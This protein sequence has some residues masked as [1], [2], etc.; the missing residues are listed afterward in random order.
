MS[1]DDIIFCGVFVIGLVIAAL[2]V[3]FTIVAVAL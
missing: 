2:P 3:A 1:K